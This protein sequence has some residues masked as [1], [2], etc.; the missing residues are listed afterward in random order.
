MNAVVAATAVAAATADANVI[1]IECKSPT[2]D[3]DIYTY[4]YIAQ[5]N[6]QQATAKEEEKN[7]RK[8]NQ[9]TNTMNRNPVEDQ[10]IN[11]T[12]GFKFEWFGSYAIR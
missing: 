9:C 3:M 4:I 11:Y 2:P 1:V 7:T 12:I 6:T 10:T 5:K 8:T